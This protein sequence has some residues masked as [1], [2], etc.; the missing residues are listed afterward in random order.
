MSL[1]F[2]EISESKHR[3]QNPFSDEKL[4][5]LG[6][7][8]GL[9]EGMRLLDLACGKGEMLARWAQKFGVI[10]VGVDISEVFIEAAK[11]RAY[12]LDVGDKLDFVVSDAADY[13]QEHHQFDVVSCI[14]AT[15]I[16]GGLVGTLE[17]MRTAIKPRDGILLVGEPFWHEVPPV[18]FCTA[19]GVEQDTFATLEGTLDRIESAGFTLVEM[20]LADLDNWD[21][22]VA[23]QW[24]TVHQFLHEN[25][26]DKDTTELQ[27]WIA[28]SRRAYLA[29]GRRYMGWGVF[30]LRPMEGGTKAAPRQRENPDRPVKVNIDGEMLW[31]ELADG[32][33]IGNP[34]RW[35][36]WLESATAE[37]ASTVDITGSTIEW[38]LLAQELNVG[39]LLRARW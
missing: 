12:L 15:W 37:Q 25:P 30:V 29:Y 6:E 13:P 3:I 11:E 1:R 24:M 8:S 9:R 23:R 21:R 34:V 36:S 19:L 14:G 22:Y 17:L 28:D 10:G 4:M 7:I 20:V 26:D 35:Y 32:R 27:H 33:V 16:G 2:H 18:D 31:V 5:L 39:A 38:P